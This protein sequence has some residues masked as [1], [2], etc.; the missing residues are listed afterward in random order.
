MRC[1]FNDK[2]S[3]YDKLLVKANIT[4]P[5]SGLLSLKSNECN[6][7]GKMKLILPRANTSKYGLHTFRYYGPKMWSSLQDELRIAPT[8]K[9][10]VSQIRKMTLDACSCFFFYAVHRLDFQF[11]RFHVNM[12]CYYFN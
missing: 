9:H 5:I 1:I 8:I 7:R 11:S 3:T 6:L 2:F 4:T 12:F 10:F